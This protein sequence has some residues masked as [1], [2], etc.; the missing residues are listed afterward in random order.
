MRARSLQSGS[1]E[2]SIFVDVEAEL[3]TLF[4][5][6]R[7]SD[8]SKGT[9]VVHRAFGPSLAMT[10]ETF[11]YVNMRDP[12][13]KVNDVHVFQEGDSVELGEVVVHTIMTPHDAD[14]SVAFVVEHA[15]KRLGILTD[16]GYT[17]SALG[18]L[19]QSLD[20]VF[21][22]SNYDPKMLENGPYPEELKRRI[23]GRGGHI[24][25]DESALLLKK[26]GSQRLQWACLAHLS[27][28]NNQPEVA[29]R[30][31]HRVN[32]DHVPLLVAD[33]YGP[34]GVFEVK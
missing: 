18:P 21:L 8:H 13:V 6:H 24:S 2:H 3:D 22:E 15:G 23:V 27:Q 14:G 28:E 16:L 25:N 26:H 19:L 12:K 1:N 11:R 10:H 29:L 31:H 34:T 32:G 5:S 33:R 20:A 30:T 17:F 7:H 4:V 9:G